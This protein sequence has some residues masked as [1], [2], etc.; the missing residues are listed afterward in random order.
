MDDVSTPQTISRSENSSSV[1]KLIY[2]IS[3]DMSAPLRAVVQLSQMLKMK[4][5]DKLNDK[6]TYWLQLI[7][8]SGS[9]A[10]K[11]I[12]ALLIYSKLTTHRQPDSSFQLIQPLE[13]AVSALSNIT[14]DKSATIKIEGDW[15][16]Y[17]GCEE[18]W[19]LLFNCLIHNALLYQSKETENHPQ[20]I[21]RCEQ[22]KQQLV[23]SVEDNG[24]GVQESLWPALTTPFK[25][26]QSDKDYLGLGM[27]LTYCERIAELHNGNLQIKKST[28]GGLAVIYTECLQ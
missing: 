9:H 11:M 4:A 13:Q 26:M 17:T 28:L 7:E 8:E 12:E 1:Q 20:V 24:I 10:Q 3:H 19:A 2:G 5:G 23:V 21:I 14:Q 22:S 6:E 25:R 18:Q 27:G 15:P 16:Q